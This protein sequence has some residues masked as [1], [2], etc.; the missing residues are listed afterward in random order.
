MSVLP[1]S[2][3]NGYCDG[4]CD[5]VCQ[6]GGWPRATWQIKEHRLRQRGASGWAASPETRR[7]AVPDVPELS[8][9]VEGV[10]MESIVVAS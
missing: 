4:G 1:R 3:Y 10:T 7:E 2:R 8:V 6:A 5:V 9:P